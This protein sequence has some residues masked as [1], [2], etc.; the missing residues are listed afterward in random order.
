MIQEINPRDF[1]D[2][3]TNFKPSNHDSYLW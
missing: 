3:G 1:S 2:S